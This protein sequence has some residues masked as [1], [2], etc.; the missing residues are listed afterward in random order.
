M[1][2]TLQNIF[3][4]RFGKHLTFRVQLLKYKL[5][6]ASLVSYVVQCCNQNKMVVANKL[7]LGMLLV[8]LKFIPEWI[9]KT[10]INFMV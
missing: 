4:F 6:S 9:N 3:I 8:F 1:S 10:K 2:G 5:P 7:F